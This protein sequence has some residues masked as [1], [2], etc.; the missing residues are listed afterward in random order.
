MRVP[1]CSHHIAADVENEMVAAFALLANHPV[2][3]YNIWEQ[4]VH[5][6]CPRSMRYVPEEISMHRL[7]AV[8]S[9]RTTPFILWSNGGHYQAVVPMQRFHASSDILGGF[10][11]TQSNVVDKKDL[12]PK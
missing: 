3:V 8:R 6:V 4:H 1:L 5:V 11:Y 10:R 7:S 9:V 12:V 2:V